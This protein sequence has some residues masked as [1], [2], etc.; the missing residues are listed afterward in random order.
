MISDRLRQWTR[1]LV[2]PV[3]RALHRL[4]VTPNVLTVIGFLL[5][6]MNAWLL[7]EGRLPLAGALI[8]AFTAL[9]AFDGTLARLTGQVTRFGAFLDSVL[10]R[11]AEAVLF[12][13]L[14]VFFNRAGSDGSVYLYLTFAAMI[15]SFM[16][17]YTRARAEGLGLTCKSGWFTRV[18]RILLLSAGLLTGWVRPMLWLLA[19]LANVT[20]VQRM[21]HVYRATRIDTPSPSAKAGRA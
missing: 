20:A 5:T 19:V 9:D 18:E 14:F 17:S 6:S 3:A 12:L 21:V 15:G 11:F 13:G 8:L 10:D 16:V 1:W 2:E 7:A 4:G